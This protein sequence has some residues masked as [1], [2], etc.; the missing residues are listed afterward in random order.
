MDIKKHWKKT[1]PKISNKGQ[2]ANKETYDLQ[3][4]FK[5]NTKPISTIDL[6]KIKSNEYKFNLEQI[7]EKFTFMYE[8]LKGSRLF[9]AY[10]FHI[11]KI[12][13]EDKEMDELTAQT[14]EKES[15]VYNW[16][17]HD[18][19]SESGETLA[20][21]IP[22]KKQ[23]NYVDKFSNN[24]ENIRPMDRPKIESGYSKGILSTFE[25]VRKKTDLL[26]DKS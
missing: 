7:I 2:C 10:G 22:N 21:Y 12:E 11:P 24:K 6:T 25:A 4:I 26:L 8:A 5:Y 1:F 16:Q 17:V 14:T 13:N 18:W 15:G 9:G 23:I 20:D 19:I 3:E